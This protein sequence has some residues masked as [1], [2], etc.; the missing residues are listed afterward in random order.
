MLNY[1]DLKLEIYQKWN[2]SRNSRVTLWNREII[3]NTSWNRE[4]S[5]MGYK[6]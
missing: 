5:K 1:V 2:A 6:Q 3:K 4:E